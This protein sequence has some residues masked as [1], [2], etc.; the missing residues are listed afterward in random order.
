MMKIASLILSLACMLGSHSASAAQQNTPFLR[1][2][3]LPMEA[4]REI[5]R[6]LKPMLAYLEK[7]LGVNIQIVYLQNYDAILDAF[8]HERIDLA[9]LG[10]LPYVILTDKGAQAQPLVRFL[11]AEG[12]DTYT[13]SLLK[14]AL[15]EQGPEEFSEM[16]VALTQPYSTCGYLVTADLLA[17]IGLPIAQARYRYVGSHSKVALGIAQGRFEIGGIKT[18]IGRKFAHLGLKEVRQSEALPGFVMVGNQTTLDPKRLSQIR[19][20]LLKL[21]PLQNPND[22]QLMQHWGKN[23]RYGTVPA[24]DK[25]FSLIRSK[26]K[27]LDLPLKGNF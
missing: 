11:D 1:F 5:I 3:P 9:F 8:L 22:A 27:A 15:S 18:S 7:E 26:L 23:I 12:K 17:Q 6:Q 16:R 24:A 2:A 10:P 4:P 13:C 14:S 19:D 25:D 21:K 20:S